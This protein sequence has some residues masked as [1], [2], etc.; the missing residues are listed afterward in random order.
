MYKSSQAEKVKHENYAIKL[1]KILSSKDLSMLQDTVHAPGHSACPSFQD[2]NEIY[3]IL[4]SILP[5]R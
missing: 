4:W 2:T 5:W 1:F 3:F